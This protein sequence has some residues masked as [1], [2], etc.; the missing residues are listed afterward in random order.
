M[1]FID[2]SDPL[3]QNLAVYMVELTTDTLIH[4]RNAD[5]QKYPA[6]LTKIMTA[7]LTLISPT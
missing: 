3:M 7:I 2:E 6:S 5:V 1:P 4:S